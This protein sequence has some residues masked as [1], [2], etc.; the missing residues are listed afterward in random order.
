[1]HKIQEIGEKATAI[2]GEF[3]LIPASPPDSSPAPPPATF[4]FPSVALPVRLASV[5]LAKFPIGFVTPYSVP[6]ISDALAH[7]IYLVTILPH[8]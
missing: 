5:Y 8:L 2:H 3:P 4:S 7:S 6:T 1:M